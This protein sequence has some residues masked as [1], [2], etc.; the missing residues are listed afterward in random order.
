MRKLRKKLLKP[1]Y[2][3]T[4][5]VYLYQDLPSTNSY[6]RDN[7]DLFKPND[8]VRAD[9]QTS[10][11]G[12]YSKTWVNHRNES[13]TFSLALAEDLLGNSTFVIT[14]LMAL[15][16]TRTLDEFG[17][18]S[19]IKYPNDIMVDKKKIAGILVE[20][21]L[22][23]RVYIIGMGINVNFS[24]KDNEVIDQ[25]YTSMHHYSKEVS[26]QNLFEKLLVNLSNYLEVWQQKGFEPFTQQWKFKSNL[27]N[28]YVIINQGIG[29]ILS[30]KVLSI[31]G[32]GRLSIA[33]LEENLDEKSGKKSSVKDR[34]N[35]NAKKQA[36]H[37]MIKQEKRVFLS[38]NS[39]IITIKNGFYDE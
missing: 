2:W 7:Y 32:E 15:S 31:D 34:T 33:P 39:H 38:D 29:G 17:L 14:Q 23:E 12:Q 13:L 8:I 35:D 6:L 9:L 36:R 25:P 19:F 30:G 37:L 20:R 18:A 21:K 5:D 11:R 22:S 26:V 4:G 16:L 1:P 27:I 3:Q 28:K 10:G 24:K